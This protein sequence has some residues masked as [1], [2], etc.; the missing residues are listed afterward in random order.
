MKYN[1]VRIALDCLQKYDTTLPDKF[2]FDHYLKS[3]M[4]NKCINVPMVDIAI[5][6]GQIKIISRSYYVHIAKLLGHKSIRASIRSG[7][8]IL[9]E[10]FNRCIIDADVSGELDAE[11]RNVDNTRVVDLVYFDRKFDVLCWGYILDTFSAF[12]AK[13]NLKVFNVQFNAEEKFATFDYEM[14]LLGHSSIA[15]DL[16]GLHLDWH[17]KYSII[18]L[19]GVKFSTYLPR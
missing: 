2:I 11:G 9:I 8:N 14:L 4:L 3:L 17:N 6:D 12:A 10:Q 5:E 1:Y 15:N 19:N 16:Y 13:N 7:Y 18:S